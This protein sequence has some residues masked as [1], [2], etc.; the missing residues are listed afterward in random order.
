M[1]HEYGTNTDIEHLLFRYFCTLIRGVFYAIKRLQMAEKDTT[2]QGYSDGVFWE[3]NTLKDMKKN[4][5]HN[6]IKAI[7]ELPLFSNTME[8]TNEE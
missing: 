8:V 7:G 5:N 3:R 6:R 4:R 1:K 2:I